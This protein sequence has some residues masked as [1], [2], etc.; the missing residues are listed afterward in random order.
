MQRLFVTTLI[1]LLAFSVGAS[2][3]DVLHVPKL[4]NPPIIDG[5]LDDWKDVAFNDGV[6]DIRRNATEPWYD[7]GRRNRLTNQSEDGDATLFE[8]LQANYF[9]AWDDEWIYMG[10][11]VVDNYNDLDDP[12]PAD[13]RWMFK[14]S[15][16]WFLEAPGDDAPEN[17]A[18]GDNAFCFV[19]D[20]SHSIPGWWRHGSADEVYLEDPIPAEGVEFKV[21][22]NPWG[23][24]EGDFILEAKVKMDLTFPVS[25]PSWKP[26]VIGDEYRME[27]V[28]C[29]PDGGDYGGHFMIYG[30]GDDDSTWAKMILS[31]PVEPVQRLEK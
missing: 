2:A 31:P 11:E 23:T 25:D 6:W 19:A 29:D 30:T 7:D 28:H 1:L 18:R 24:G 8:D 15:I 16:C 4:E 20:D 10:A 14:D 27:I 9:I 22:M 26:P 17:F 5:N 21:T 13:R 12:A 3:Q